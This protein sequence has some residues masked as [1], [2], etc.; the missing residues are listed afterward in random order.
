MCPVY[1]AEH[2]ARPASGQVQLPGDPEA[3]GEP[4]EPGAEAVV[5]DRHEHGPAVREP[6]E[7]RVQLGLALALDEQ[8]GRRG[9]G[10]RV[11]DWVVGGEKNPPPPSVKLASLTEPSAPISPG[12]Y[13]STCVTSESPK[14]ET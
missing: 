1:H 8:G 6:G 9:E 2:A 12:P 14:S 13:R 11:L 10:E 5:A 3:V 7:G 4:A